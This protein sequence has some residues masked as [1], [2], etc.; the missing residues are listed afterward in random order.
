[1]CLLLLFLFQSCERLFSSLR[2]F[3][4][5]LVVHLFAGAVSFIVLF[6]F[7]C[8]VSCQG[9]SWNLVCRRLFWCTFHCC[10]CGGAIGLCVFISVVAQSSFK[11]IVLCLLFDHLRVCCGHF[12][13]LFQLQLQI[14]TPSNSAHHLSALTSLPAQSDENGE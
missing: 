14:H 10:F 12:S 7:Q 1:M 6:F 11:K 8:L 5:S 13:F 2:L 3:V 4:S 9:R